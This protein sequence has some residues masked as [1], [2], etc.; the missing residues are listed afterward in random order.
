[1]S[2]S[3]PFAD[4]SARYAARY[5]AAGFGIR[6]TLCAMMSKW[7]ANANR[8]RKERE[9][10]V[11]SSGVIGYGCEHRILQCVCAQMYGVIWIMWMMMMFVITITRDGF[12]CVCVSILRRSAEW[13]ALF[14]WWQ[15]QY[16]ELYGNEII[17]YQVQHM[18][19][20]ENLFLAD[21]QSFDSIRESNL[22]QSIMEKKLLDYEIE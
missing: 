21:N 3:L 11:G 1:M 10:C 13:T 7:D 12:V 14:V 4:A 16:M 20:R 19:I 18:I 9:S 2:L 22:I 6:T 5:S 17:W 8:A 15:F